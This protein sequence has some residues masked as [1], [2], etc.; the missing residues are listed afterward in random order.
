MFQCKCKKCKFKEWMCKLMAKKPKAN[1]QNNTIKNI[2]IVFSAFILV[3]GALLVWNNR[4]LSFAG[5]VDGQRI[6]LAQL[7]FFHSSQLENMMW[8]MWEFGIF[9]VTQEIH[10]MAR[11]QAWTELVN[12]HIITAR[13][14]GL[15]VR[16][17]AEAMAEVD[18]LV[19]NFNEI[20]GDLIREWGFSNAS[21]RRFVELM[22]L[23]DRVIDHI[24]SSYSYTQEELDAFIAENI[25]GINSVFVYFVEVD[26]P[27][28]ADS[29]RM[30]V[31][32]GRSIIEV[33]QEYCLFY[34]PENLLLDEDELPIYELNIWFTPLNE[35]QIAFAYTLEEG[36]LSDIFVLDNGH[37]AFFQVVEIV[38]EVEFDEVLEI[39]VN[40][41]RQEIFVNEMTIWLEQARIEENG[42]LFN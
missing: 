18:E 41:L 30:Q 31:N 20:F 19:E 9:E 32:M 29:L 23:Q 3:V 5:T 4:S 15:G 12:L 16:L 11:Q 21:F 37:F 40:R 33:I 17:D 26:S 42:R 25:L 6:P 8:Q 39:F 24:S 14:D 10:E 27:M 7:N 13:A 2:V 38:E 22:V 1:S 36:E 34:N 35:D 28:E